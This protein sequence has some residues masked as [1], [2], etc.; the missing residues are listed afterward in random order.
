VKSYLAWLM[1]KG[2]L[3]AKCESNLLLWEAAE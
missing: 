3:K 1:D 2:Q